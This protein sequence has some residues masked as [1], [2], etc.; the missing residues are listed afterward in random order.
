[1]IDT[2]QEKTQK[3]QEGLAPSIKSRLA[4]LMLVDYGDAIRRAMVIEDNSVRANQDRQ[5]Q[6]Q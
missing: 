3:F 5:T 6:Q 2:P 4:P 1:M